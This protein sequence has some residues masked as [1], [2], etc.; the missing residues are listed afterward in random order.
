MSSATDAFGD[1]TR[2]VADCRTA[3]FAAREGLT[4]ID[5]AD[6]ERFVAALIEGSLRFVHQDPARPTFVPWTTAERR[7]MDNGRDSAYWIAAVDGRRRYRMHGRRGTECYLSFTV[8]AGSPGH[9][10]SVAEN[11]NHLDLGAAA[12]GAYTVEIA[13]PADACYVIARQYYLDP[14]T[15]RPATMHIQAVGGPA[16]DEP[17]HDRL[18]AGWRAAAGFLD[19]MSQPRSGGGT[20]P[21]WV[22]T[23]PNVMGDPS[24]WSADH[25]GGRGTPDQV[26]AMGP[27]TLEED[28][29][30]VVDVTFLPCA[31]AGVALWNRFSQT[32]DARLH[33]STLNHR[34]A[35]V[36]A[37]GVARVVVAHRDPGVPNWVDTGGRPRG[38]VYWRFLLA[39]RLP[40]PLRSQVV[41]LADL[42]GSREGPAA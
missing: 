17:G 7:W 40:S 25:G 31:Y 29:A 24:A 14:D 16:P 33:R 37:D 3:V 1:Y 10:E 41:R 18:D 35:V 22:S 4:P 5:A 8:Y 12:G 20:R 36:D 9:P 26:Y 39:E 42:P 28:E 2:A 38:S 11:I 30:L 34:Q 27:Y 15:D 21:R 23:I 13:P 19:A 6:G 32:I